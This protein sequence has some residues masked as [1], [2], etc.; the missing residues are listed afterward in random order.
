ML[1]MPTSDA[2]W[3][4]V[5]SPWTHHYQSRP[6]YKQVWVLG[7]ERETPDQALYGLALFS[8]SYGQ[9]SA[10]AYYGHV[11]NNVSSLSESLYVKVS[12]GI[13]YG[14]VHP[15]EDRMP[16]NYR[17]FAPV[18]IPGIGWRLDPDWSI[19]TI[20]PGPDVIV[21]TLSRRF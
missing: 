17:G 11:F 4:L 18:I 20:F 16:L 2:V 13:I 6:E 21:F 7:L 14:Y 3:H 8:N 9:P 19:Q 1:L 15:Y 5:I 12:V 10:Y